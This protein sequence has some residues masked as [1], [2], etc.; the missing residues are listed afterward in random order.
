M[1]GWLREITG[2]VLPAECV[3]CGAAHSTLCE[4]C[5]GELSGRPAW[6][7]WP[8][9]VPE[10][11]P[12]VFT[13]AW[14]AGPVRA[15]LLA[16]KERGA[17]TLAE[18][19]GGA[20]AGAVRRAGV[21]GAGRG[22]RGCSAPL[23]LVPVPSARTAVR[24]RGHDAG[25]RLARAAAGALCRSGVPARVAPVL[26]QRRT[27]ADQAGLDARQRRANVAGAL[28]VSRGAGHLWRESGEVVLVD[29]LMTTGSS[30][31][32]AARAVRAS[33]GRVT[34]AAVVAVTPREGPATGRRRQP[35]LAGKRHRC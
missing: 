29:D 18:P 5:R 33:G 6:R 24:R 16:H 3:G 9:P 14:Y 15:A 23:L 12:P 27:V 25:R 8:D 30:L 19:L 2:L 22:V 4:G 20:L 28:A 31:L 26:A 13:A 10:G 35:E 34:G 11:L 32:E 7:A 1:R 21:L 17:L